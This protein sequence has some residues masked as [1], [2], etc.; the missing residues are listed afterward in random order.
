M[1]LLVTMFLLVLINV[2]HADVVAG[3]LSSLEVGSSTVADL[4]RASSYQARFVSEVRSSPD[5]V[6]TIYR[7]RTARFGSRSFV[8]LNG[9]LITTN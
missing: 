2:A 9:K 3:E 5:R 1:K 4:K 7:V 8:F 6:Y